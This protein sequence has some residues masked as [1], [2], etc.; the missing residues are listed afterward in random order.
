[1]LPDLAAIL[2]QGLVSEHFAGMAAVVFGAAL[3]QGIGGIGFAMV[4][5]PISVLLFP[6][7]V[8]GPLLVLGTALALLG[9]VRDFRDINW[10]SFGIIMS[11]RVVRHHRGRGNHQS[12]LGDAVLGRA[13]RRSS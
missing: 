2:P 11:G 12:P 8:P 10:R 4:S 13:R 7:L 5:A 1:M 9:A 6:E 3:T